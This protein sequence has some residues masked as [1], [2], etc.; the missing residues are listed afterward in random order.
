MPQILQM[1]QPLRG[2]L[3]YYQKSGQ[4]LRKNSIPLLIHAEQ[5]NLNFCDALKSET[6]FRKSQIST[7]E[8][9]SLTATLADI[10][11]REDLRPL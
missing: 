10:S 6:I 8:W 7:E 11:S 3:V 2:S 9:E 1:S 5:N 4:R